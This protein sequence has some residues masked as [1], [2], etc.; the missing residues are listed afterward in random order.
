MNGY[1]FKVPERQL[2]ERGRVSAGR[3]GI[4]AEFFWT[5]FSVLPKPSGLTGFA[6]EK[7]RFSRRATGIIFRQ[8][9]LLGQML[10]GVQI[11]LRVA[12][13]E[14]GIRCDVGE[15]VQT[16][17]IEIKARSDSHFILLA[18]NQRIGDFAAVQP[19]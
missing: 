3:R 10:E 9:L 6:T 5:L 14:I 12:A 13:V 18:L 2:Q 11:L 8:R 15:L 7:Q 16:S 19:T 1:L 17:T 4:E